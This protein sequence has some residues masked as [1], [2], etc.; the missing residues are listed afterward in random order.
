MFDGKS[1]IFIRSKMMAVRNKATSK[2]GK[3]ILAEPQLLFIL[4][5]GVPHCAGCIEMQLSSLKNANQHIEFLPSHP[6]HVW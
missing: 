4:G 5:E 6:S 2:A 1:A 3:K